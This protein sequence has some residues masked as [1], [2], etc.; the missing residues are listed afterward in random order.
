MTNFCKQYNK[1]MKRLKDK[2]TTVNSVNVV[3]GTIQ[4]VMVVFAILLEYNEAIYF[5]V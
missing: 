1:L 3:S 2:H 4:I 5:S